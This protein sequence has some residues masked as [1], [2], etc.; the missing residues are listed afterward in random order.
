MPNKIMVHIKYLA[1]G[2]GVVLCLLATG[3]VALGSDVVMDRYAWS[4]NAGWINFNPQCDGCQGVTVYI[5]HLEG[6]AW[7]ENVGWIRLGTYTGGGSYTYANDAAGT[8][9]VNV[10]SAG[11]LSGYAWSKNVGWIK[12]DPNYGSVTVNLSSGDLEGYAW[13]ENVGWIYFNHTAVS[14]E[15]HFLYLPLVIRQE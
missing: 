14:T 15:G 10:D 4:K 12:F 2:A 11:N 8:Y 1:L 5:D 13:G 7:G 9:G 6:Y 3:Q